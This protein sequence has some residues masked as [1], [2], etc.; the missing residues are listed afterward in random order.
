[1]CQHTG[2]S[3]DK[4]EEGAQNSPRPR[5]LKTSAVAIAALLVVSPLPA[6]E[7]IR[8]AF[9]DAKEIALVQQHVVTTEPSHNPP[10]L[11]LSPSNASSELYGRGHGSH[12]SH[13]SHRSHYSGSGGGGHASHTSHRSHYSGSGGG[14][15][16]GAKPPPSTPPPTTPAP[17]S[18]PKPPP[19][20]RPARPSPPTTRPSGGTSV[21]EPEARKYPF[22]VYTKEPRTIYCDVKP[23][24]E[25]LLLVK[26]A[27][28]IRV[29]MSDVER[30][31]RNPQHQPTT[32]PTTQPGTQP[33]R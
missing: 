22:I 30:I 10:P 21:E 32:E 31:E 25:D 7:H 12:R 14:G 19:E 8:P 13:S 4:S 18:P 2:A 20:R 3:M 33:A 16:G 23:D 6:S 11:V 17:S 24:G 15:G 26:R 5:R 27:G 29:R 1:M 28:T 9:Q